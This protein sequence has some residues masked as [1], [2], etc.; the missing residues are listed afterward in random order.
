MPKKLF[1]DTPQNFSFRH[2]IY[3]HGWCELLPFEIDETNWRLNYVFT[4]V[5]LTAPVAGEISESEG[6]I[7]IEIRGGKTNRQA[8]EKILRDVR[9]IL[10]LD[11]NLGDFYK[12]T[13]T[14]K[15]LDWIGK[16]NAG[17]LLRSPTVYEDLVK[18]ICTTN[19]SW[20]LTKKMTANLVEKLGDKTTAGKSAFPTAE[21][22]AGVSVDFYRN[23]I[24]AGYRSAYF[25]E[26]AEK[27]ANGKINPESWLASDLPTNEL[28]KEM[29]SIKG[30]GDY[31][32]ENLLKLVGR[33]DGLA[34][35]SWL[36]SQFYKKHNGEQICHDKQIEKHY[37]RFGDWRG[38]AIWCDMTERW[39]L[40]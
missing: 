17:R 19:C 28:K 33:Y 21:Q 32:A 10:R 38:L 36:R 34:L 14:E 31:A 35:D 27:V 25:A 18:T 4:D 24:R 26:L 1:L 30:V 3:S 22:M 40:K 15:K 9:H 6:K 5:S 2:T 12:Y 7:K 23:E 20:A 11:D 16:Q 29:K 37:E 39:F 13:K 8:E